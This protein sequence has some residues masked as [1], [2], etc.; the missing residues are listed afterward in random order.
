MSAA[1]AAMLSSPCAGGGAGSGE[2]GAG[3][4]CTFGGSRSSSARDGE[5]AAMLA[6]LAAATAKLNDLTAN[7]AVA[8]AAA[9]SRASAGAASELLTAQLALSAAAQQ[10]AVGQRSQARLTC[11]IGRA[12]PADGPVKQAGGGTARVK[13]EGPLLQ[14]LVWEVQLRIAIL[15]GW[16]DAC[17]LWSTLH[18]AGSSNCQVAWREL[19][20]AFVAHRGHDSAFLADLSM[21]REAPRYQMLIGAYA[22]LHPDVIKKAFSQRGSPNRMLG[23]IVA[24]DDAS[25]LRA[26][27]DSQRHQLTVEASMLCTAIERSASRC[28]ELLLDEAVAKELGKNK[29]SCAGARVRIEYPA[30]SVADVLGQVSPLSSSSSSSAGS[31]FIDF[32]QYPQRLLWA[33]AVARSRAL[34][35]RV[36]A[37]LRERAAS[38]KPI[39][40]GSQAPASFAD[41]LRLW[42]ACC[43]AA[44]GHVPLLEECGSVALAGP[45]ARVSFRA[46]CALGSSEV[47]FEDTPLGVIAAARG[48]VGAL[49]ALARLGHDLQLCSPRGLTAIDAARQHRSAELREGLLAVLRAAG[50]RPLTP[51]AGPSFVLGAG[52]GSTIT[53]VTASVESDA[54]S[55]LVAAIERGDLPMVQRLLKL[56]ARLEAEDLMAAVRSGDLE[57]LAFVQTQCTDA[58]GKAEYRKMMRKTA[59][60]IRE[61]SRGRL[62][63][64]LPS[65]SSS[66]SLRQAGVAVMLHK[67]SL[68]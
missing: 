41:H 48:Q 54:G 55:P 11:D 39:A 18:P 66:S 24:S 29:G 8:P 4:D 45:L 32:D 25:M 51:S 5:T 31:D 68:A 35:D 62:R 38:T 60:Q 19:I 40:S 20:S 10:I 67:P 14:S 64:S 6:S 15:L 22:E 30:R 63:N 42:A 52:R 17:S 44:C 28:V 36:L 43:G 46:P 49:E 34:S 56:G 37:Y 23:Q 58:S 16:H 3:L 7:P 57:V 59:Q 21:L 9:R 2:Y 27:L 26:F 33:A 1:S 61:N 47:E 12:T 50:A 65:S 13:Q 53:A